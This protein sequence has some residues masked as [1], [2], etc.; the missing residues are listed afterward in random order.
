VDL[1]GCPHPNVWTANAR[2][3]V[4]DASS[5]SERRHVA[6]DHRDTPDAVSSAGEEVRL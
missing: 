5:A 4:R 1:G 6:P 3:E 2:I